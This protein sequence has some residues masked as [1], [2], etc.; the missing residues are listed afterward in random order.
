M[1]GCPLKCGRHRP[2]LGQP[3]QAVPPAQPCTGGPLSPPLA[4]SRP[5]F[6]HLHPRKLDV[7]AHSACPP[8]CPL[9]APRSGLQQDA[10]LGDPA[11][12]E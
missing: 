8:L 4:L 11:G 5:Q 7:K 9:S 12:V 10:V 2:A 3:S 1:R 6:P